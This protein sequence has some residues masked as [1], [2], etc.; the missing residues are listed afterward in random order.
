[1]A[2]NGGVALKGDAPVSA[3]SDR[4]YGYQCVRFGSKADAVGTIARNELRHPDKTSPLHAPAL[5]GPDYL[6]FFFF[7]C[8]AAFFSFMVLAGFFLSLFFESIPLLILSP[9]SWL[10]SVAAYVKPPQAFA[11]AWLPICARVRLPVDP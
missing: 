4:R 1:M 9:P 2:R 10:S 3:I 6:A 11:P 5:W 8:L 7:S